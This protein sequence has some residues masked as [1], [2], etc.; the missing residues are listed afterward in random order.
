LVNFDTSDN[1]GES[2]GQTYGFP[3]ELTR[4]VN[5]T[6]GVKIGLNLG[7]INSGQGLAPGSYELQP[8][9]GDELSGSGSGCIVDHG[10]GFGFGSGPLFSLNVTTSGT[11]YKVGE[12]YTI[13][14]SANSVV[15]ILAI[16]NDGTITNNDNSNNRNAQLIRPNNI[17]GGIMDPLS[18]SVTKPAL[19]K[20][21]T[22]KLPGGTTTQTSVTGSTLP[23]FN[24]SPLDA[25]GFDDIEGCGGSNDPLGCVEFTDDGFLKPFIQQETIKIPRGVYGV[26][27]LGTLVS[28]QLTK[29]TEDDYISSPFSKLR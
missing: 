20:G 5:N 27:Q 16:S 7:I 19:I 26:N 8:I 21:K 24:F 25:A 15:V 3:E 22:S 2:S 23:R 6:G 9:I 29:T 28:D 18:N 1:P 12:R 14:E 11:G 10:V 4:Y 17:T 13:S